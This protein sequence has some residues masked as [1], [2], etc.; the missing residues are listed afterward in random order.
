MTSG[1]S[2]LGL[3]VALGL[4]VIPAETRATGVAAGYARAALVSAAWARLGS[5]PPSAAATEPAAAAEPMAEPDADPPGRHE[6]EAGLRAYE[7]G[8]YDVA[9]EHFERAY[10]LDRA[11]AYLY[12]WAQAAR[13]AGDCQAAVDLYRRFVDAGAQGAQREAALQNQA[14]CEAQLAAVPV[15]EPQ[16]PEADPEPPQAAPE[17]ED[18]PPPRRRPDPLGWSLLATGSA[19]TVVGAVL[20]GLGEARR[21]TQHAQTQ[22]DRFDELDVQIDRFH[23]AGGV[24]LGV[25][26]ALVIGGV[27][28]LVLAR[29]RSSSVARALLPLP[30]AVGRGWALRGPSP[31][32]MRRRRVPPPP[33]AAW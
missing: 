32:L 8:D 24:T 19:A 7:R 28:R 5:A 22:Y 1:R 4:L 17:P 18:P 14:R 6:L 33:A 20:V 13:K 15:P 2:I 30:R 27:V 3:S 9:I 23:I 11:P 25:G 16:L 12:A 21:A 10:A 29:R 31:R 26:M